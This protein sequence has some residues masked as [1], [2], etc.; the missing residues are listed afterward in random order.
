MKKKSCLE[1]NDW[2]YQVFDNEFPAMFR[3]NTR[4]HPYGCREKI[5]LNLQSRN[6]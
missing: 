4:G 1:R 2:K 5:Q 6:V 3:Q